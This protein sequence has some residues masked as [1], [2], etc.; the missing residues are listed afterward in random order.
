MHPMHSYKY[1][2][3]IFHIYQHYM[4]KNNTRKNHLLSKE[5]L[6]FNELLSQPC[7]LAKLFHP[8]NGELLCC[9]FSGISS[10]K[11]C[12]NDDYERVCFPSPRLFILPC[13]MCW[14]N[15]YVRES[16]R[17][18]FILFCFCFSTTQNTIQSISHQQIST[19]LIGSD[20]CLNF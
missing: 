14:K 18:V 19:T 13:K 4:L 20:F 5:A 7:S 8:S 10:L 17:L 12:E 3:F 1:P 9:K 16:V 2:I 6:W 11:K 15:S